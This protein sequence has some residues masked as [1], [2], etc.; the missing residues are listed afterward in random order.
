MIENKIFEK[1]IPMS[2]KQ[3]YAYQQEN[4]DSVCKIVGYPPFNR[5][6]LPYPN[7]EGK[8]IMRYELEIKK[9]TGNSLQVDFYKYFRNGKIE[10]F[11]RTMSFSELINQIFKNLEVSQFEQ[12]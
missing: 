11:E 8:E 2:G 9:F 12:L 4:V 3:E 1:I 10:H 5:G 7:D 6:S